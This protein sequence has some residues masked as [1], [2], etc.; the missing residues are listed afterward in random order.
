VLEVEETE[1]SFFA[2]GDSR[3]QLLGRCEGGDFSGFLQISSPFL[4]PRI[5]K[6]VKGLV[7]VFRD[8]QQMAFPETP[9]RGLQHNERSIVLRQSSDGSPEVR[10]KLVRVFQRQLTCNSESEVDQ[11]GKGVVFTQPRGSTRSIWCLSPVVMLRDNRSTIRSSNFSRCTKIRFRIPRSV[12]L[13]AYAEMTLR[14]LMIPAPALSTALQSRNV[15][16]LPSLS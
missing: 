16:R 8:Q 4:S 11:S 1:E 9:D 14:P 12:L 10:R 7:H 2:I 6:T 15:A 13:G 3:E 5:A